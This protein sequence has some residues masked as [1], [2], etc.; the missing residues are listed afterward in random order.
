MLLSRLL[1]AAQLTPKSQRGDVEVTSVVCDSREAGPGTCFVAIPGTSTDGH[2]F[3]SDAVSAGSSA[4]ICEDS[5]AAVD[6]VPTALV[7]STREAVGPLAQALAGWPARKLTVVGVTGTNGKTTV[8]WL[9][10]SFLEASGHRPGLLGT[11]R[12]ETGANTIAAQTTTPDPIGLAAMMAEMVADGRTHLVMEMSSH[13]LHQQRSAGIELA[14]GVMTNVTG[15]HLDYHGTMEDY[16]A[17]KLELF[18]SLGPEATA[19]VNRD[20]PVGNAF[21]AVTSAPVIWYGLSP[22]ADVRGRIDQIDIDGTRFEIITPSWQANVTTPLIGRHNVF[23]CLAASAAAIALGVDTDVIIRQLATVR[24]IPGRLERVP[25]HK[26]F[27]VFVDYAHT[28]DALVNVLSSLRPVTKGKLIVVFGCGGDRDRTKRPRMARA[29]QTH[30]DQIVITS[31]NPRTE[32]PQAIIDE[33][34][35]GLD[36]AGRARSVIVPDR[37]SAIRQGLDMAAPGDVVLIA[38][39]GHEKYQ[40]IGGKRIDFDDVQ[41]AHDLMA[42]GD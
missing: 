7:D 11:I 33:I 8:T 39:K 19:I 10:R 37:R 32:D 41:V 22:A 1:K 16:L 21:A 31:D 40:A 20:D 36:A 4:V 6:G 24:H 28:D 15:D 42:A 30:A 17:A 29:A 26:G 18:R 23:N 13:A 2:R 38:G 25:T 27:A 12:Y 35:V 34:V 5:S 9:L 14:V 3:I